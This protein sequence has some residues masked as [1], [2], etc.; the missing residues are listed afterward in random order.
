MYV[1][2]AHSRQGALDLESIRDL[3]LA[4]HKCHMAARQSS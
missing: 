3:G 1:L 4:Q 2:A